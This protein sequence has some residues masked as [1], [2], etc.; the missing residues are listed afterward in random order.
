MLEI[1]VIAKRVGKSEHQLR[2]VLRALTPLLDGRTKRG[3]D[4]RILVDDSG[5]A[6][7]ERAVELWSGGSTRNDKGTSVVQ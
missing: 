2:R 6:L 1:P 4:N 7:I 3:K 5:L